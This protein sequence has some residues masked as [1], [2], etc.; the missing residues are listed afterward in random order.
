MNKCSPGAWHFC[1]DIPPWARRARLSQTV[2]HSQQVRET[3]VQR[4]VQSLIN[5][6]NKDGCMDGLCWHVPPYWY[7]T[8]DI[9][10]QFILKSVYNL[11]P[12]LLQCHNRQAWMTASGLDCKFLPCNNLNFLSYCHLSLTCTAGN[13]VNISAALFFV[14]MLILCLSSFW[15][16]SY[17]IFSFIFEIVFRVCTYMLHNTTC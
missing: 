5:T 1:G 6:I 13:G 12:E 17:P 7:L 8:S 4:N 15:N 10:L 14:F 9:W 2:G 3:S 16:F 11:L